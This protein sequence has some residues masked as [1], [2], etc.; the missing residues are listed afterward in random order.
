MGQTLHYYRTNLGEQVNFSKTG[1]VIHLCKSVLPGSNRLFS[2]VFLLAGETDFQLRPKST[3]R[4]FAV[5]L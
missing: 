3:G 4:G 2:W 5:T 1:L